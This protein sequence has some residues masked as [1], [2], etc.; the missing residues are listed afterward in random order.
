MIRRQPMFTRTGTHF[1]YPTRFRP[2]AA[3]PEA[4]AAAR[5][6]A[7][8]L[9]DLALEQPFDGIVEARIAAVGARLEHG[10]QRR[11]EEHTS[12]LQSLMRISDAALCS[13]KKNSNI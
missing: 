5:P 1:P 10:V 6:V 13:K 3:R 4:G 9:E 11:S 12:E 7:L 2:P 8:E